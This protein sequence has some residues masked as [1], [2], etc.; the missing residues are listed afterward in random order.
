MV[1]IIIYLNKKENAT[2]I[3]ERLLQE[4]LVAKATID[5]DNQSYILVNEI[6]TQTTNTVVTV[7]TKMLLF[8][9]IQDLL[10]NFTGAE[11]PMYCIPILNS[12]PSFD[13]FIR[14]TT[15]KV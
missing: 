6:T 14:E 4:R 1:N 7:Q 8:E 11:V 2:Q 13:K 5:M 12:N 15:K 3:V 9:E 10:I